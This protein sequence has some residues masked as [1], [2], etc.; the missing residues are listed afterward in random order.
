MMDVKR[1]APIDVAAV[2]AAGALAP[3]AIV[4]ER[5]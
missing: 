3:E 1:V 2:S 4:G 5:A